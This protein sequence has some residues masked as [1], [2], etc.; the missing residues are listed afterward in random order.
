MA[1]NPDINQTVDEADMRMYE[2]KAR[3]TLDN[4]A[5]EARA[6]G[7]GGA[8]ALRG[9]LSEKDQELGNFLGGTGEK[10]MEGAKAAGGKLA[11][12]LGGAVAG[13]GGA[14]SGV[15]GAVSG[16]G[17]AVGQAGTTVTEAVGVRKTEKEKA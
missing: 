13:L 14:V 12:G 16:V 17:D 4:L 5:E 8:Q 9:I 11:G 6:R 2:D 1:N 3:R 15:G 10:L 7:Q